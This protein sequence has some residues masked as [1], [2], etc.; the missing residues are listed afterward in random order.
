MNELIED[1]DVEEFFDWL[2]DSFRKNREIKPLVPD[3][4]ML[5]LAWQAAQ[6]HQAYLINNG[7]AINHTIYTETAYA[8]AAADSGSENEPITL[9]YMGGKCSVSVEVDLQN[10]KNQTLRFRCKEDL[11]PEF[12]GYR[13]Q[14][15]IGETI[16]DLG[17]VSKR[18]MAKLDISGEEDFWQSNVKLILPN[19][20]LNT[21]QE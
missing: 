18:G 2:N 4:Q 19:Y 20:P 5:E 7:L 3:A 10:P 17:E 9:I 13:V 6:A 11:I 12:Q 1:P 14:I 21:E 15:Q 8:S 16:Y